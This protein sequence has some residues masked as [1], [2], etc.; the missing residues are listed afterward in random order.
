MK[1]SEE[2]ISW[3]IPDATSK[4]GVPE[5]VFFE[6][7]CDVCGCKLAKEK[8]PIYACAGMD[9][10]DWVMCTGC[11][12]KEA[13]KYISTDP[14]VKGQDEDPGVPMGNDMCLHCNKPQDQ[15]SDMG[16][17]TSLNLASNHLGSE[18]AKIIAN[19]LPKC[20]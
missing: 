6:G 20:T 16:A 17:M 4:F 11:Y 5:E 9:K 18:G 13:F 10:C 3:S 8:W 14:D 2:L 7:E 1:C 12:S 15:H 19:I